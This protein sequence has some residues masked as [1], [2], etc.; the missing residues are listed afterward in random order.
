MLSK[1]NP[2]SRPLSHSLLSEQQRLQRGKNDSQAIAG[3][4]FH[5]MLKVNRS[6][7]LFTV[8]SEPHLQL[9]RLVLHAQAERLH[10]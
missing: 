9:I 6:P 7:E 10:H 8:V 5:A 4:I 3:F 1:E 2:D